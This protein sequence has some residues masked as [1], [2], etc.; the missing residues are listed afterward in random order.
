MN[1]LT[2]LFSFRGRVGRGQFWLAWLIWF[3]VFMIIGGFAAAFATDPL[4]FWFAAAMIAGLPVSISAVLIGLKR[5]H[6]R[7]KSGLWLLAFYG[8]LL[9]PY[10]LTLMGMG[11]GIDQAAR[12]LGVSVLEFLWFAIVIWALVELGAIRGSIGG[13]QYGPDPVAP[14]PAPKAATR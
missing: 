2:L 8:I 7:N 14:K 9:F 1:L 5:L 13:N 12:P 4:G 10:I 11:K 6:D 3:G